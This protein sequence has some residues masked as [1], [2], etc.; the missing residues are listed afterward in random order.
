MQD[1]SVTYCGTCGVRIDGGEAECP[2]CGAPVVRGSNTLLTGKP[3]GMKFGRSLTL[4]GLA[5]LGLAAYLLVR[6][7]KKQA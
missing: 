4:T 5:G 3:G 7:G 2:N 6:R 1:G